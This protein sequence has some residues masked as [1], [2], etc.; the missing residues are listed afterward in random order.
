MGEGPL[1]WRRGSHPG[2]YPWTLRCKH[3]KN[4]A[5]GFVPQA[6][7]SRPALGCRPQPEADLA[8]GDQS[9][10]WVEDGGCC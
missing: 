4:Q 3:L 1:S 10:C 5:E 9:A 7:A 6:G 2:E 8:P